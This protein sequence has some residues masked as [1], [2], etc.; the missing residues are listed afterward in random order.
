[1][2][3]DAV[4]PDWVGDDIVDVRDRCQVDDRVASPDSAARDL[5]IGDVAAD[6]CVRPGRM[7]AR[8]DEVEDDRLVAAGGEDI[9]N[10]RADES[11]AAGDENPHSAASARVSSEE[12][13]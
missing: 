5:A 8:G 11:G 3:V 10:M 13:R 7:M 6:R 12:G 2:R 1:M 4:G 9:E